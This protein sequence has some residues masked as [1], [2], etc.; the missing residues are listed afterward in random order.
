MSFLKRKPK[1][2]VKSAYELGFEA[3]DKVQAIIW[4]DPDG[5][6][7]SANENFL[8]VLGYTEDEIVGRHHSMFVAPS[9]AN[10]PTDTEFWQDLAAGKARSEQFAR[11]RKDGETVYIE[12]SYNPIFG[13]DGTVEKVVKF[14]IDVTERVLKSADSSGQLDAIS[15]SQAVIEFDLDG[16]ILRANDNFLSV[17]GYSKAEV[18]GKHHR[19][20][21]DKVYAESP[22][23]KAFWQDLD[24]GKF[25][26]SEFKRFSKDGRAVWIQAS[27]NP[28]FDGEGRPYKIVKYAADITEAKTVAADQKSQMHAISGAQAVVEFELDGTIIN[29]NDN[30]LDV[31]GYELDEIVGKN[32]S[33]FVH[34]EY[35]NSERFQEFW[36]ALRRGEVHQDLYKRFAKDGGEIWLQA[37]YNPILDPDGVPYKVVKF[38]TNLTDWKS[39]LEIM[40]D[41]LLALAEGDLTLRLENSGSLDFSVMRNA[42]NK[43]ME[44][45]AEL[46]SDIHLSSAAILEESG[47][48]ADNAS[49]LSAR[50]ERQAATVEETSAS[51]EEMSGTIKSNAQNAE[52]ATKAAQSATDHAESGG[53]IV[54][55]AISAMEKIEAGSVEVR[56][57]IEVIDAIAFQTNLLA[58]NAGV[59]AARAGEAGSGFAVVASEVRALAQRASESARDISEL[60]GNSEKQVATGSDLVKKTG[61]ALNEIVSSVSV[62]S[63]GIEGIFA[64]SSE[65]ATG[66]SEINS[67][68]SEIDSTTQKTAA[69]SEEG[70]A[71]ATSLA[72]R[73][74]ALRDFV[75][76][77]TTSTS[78]SKSQQPKEQ[79]STTKADATTSMVPQEAAPLSE[80]LPVSPTDGPLALKVE[81][82]AEE[83]REF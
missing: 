18:V 11:L 67:A 34:P 56:K 36:A 21:V 47:A 12:A 26:S 77:F 65:Q 22:E 2:Q 61:D 76:Y 51:M 58:L 5:T 27:Y 43:T 23:Y 54:N 62:V 75:G 38:A 78:L 13:P 73:A 64:A 32:H 1:S 53:K 66:V 82:D 25:V 10:S 35:A 8:Q 60:I 69:I 74:T 20:F 50:C 70:T 33:I 37:S 3:L 57:I 72:Q 6:I 14:A 55:D 80:A 41:A 83:W 52:D 29:A 30:F 28:I 44:K 15:R 79:L 63:N 9:I 39:E 48:I 24:K 16:T 4:F 31:S 45:L 19:I 40:T 49:D 59:E 7:V 68:M 71:A 42:Y 81:D 17:M 46:V